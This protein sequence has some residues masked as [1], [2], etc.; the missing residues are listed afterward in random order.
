MTPADSP[1]IH[2]LIFYFASGIIGSVLACS[3]AW[4]F[5]KHREFGKAGFA[6]LFVGGLL[7]A[8][9]VIKTLDAGQNADGSWHFKIESDLK[10]LTE[11]NDKL[12]TAA[13]QV[14]ENQKQLAGA[15]TTTLQATSEVN[16]KI[17]AIKPET[18][19]YDM[20][21]K[22]VRNVPKL[23]AL[24][25]LGVAKGSIGNSYNISVEP[26]DFN[27]A[28]S[29]IL[30]LSNLPVGNQ[31]ITLPSDFGVKVTPLPLNGESKPAGKK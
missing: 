8:L 6:M 15:L 26:V 28:Y 17:A 22:E 23:T 24:T 7:I 29:S 10:R 31:A 19:N 1:P 11:E 13:R 5:V 4:V 2:S 9:P 16:A 12:Q 20:L 14:A 30:T 18:N 3:V 21:L 25:W 27:T